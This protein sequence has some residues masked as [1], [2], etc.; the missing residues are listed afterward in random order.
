MSYTKE[1]EI[2]ALKALVEM[3]G[4]FA[5]ALSEDFEKM[6]ENI[7]NDYPIFCG[8]NV[9]KSTETNDAIRGLKVKHS[10]ETQEIVDGLIRLSESISDYRIPELACN[11][12]GRV[13]VI[14]RK[15]AMGIAASKGD[16][17]FLIEQAKK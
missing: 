9:D 3:G 7:L 14:E 17:S 2:A 16:V 15:Q 5:D 4:Y 11:I 6:K 12:R 1:K 10:N 8:T 13:F